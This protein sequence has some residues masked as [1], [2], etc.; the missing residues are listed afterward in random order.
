MKLRSVLI[1][2]ITALN[3]S[4][5]IH[6][7]KFKPNSQQVYWKI[8]GCGEVKC[9]G[10]APTHDTTHVKSSKICLPLQFF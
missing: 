4:V 2:R 9:R 10:T 3:N 5:L 1:S 6:L 8:P 7:N